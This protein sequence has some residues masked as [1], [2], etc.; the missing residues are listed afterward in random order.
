VA[1]RYDILGPLMGSC[2]HF[3]GHNRHFRA[4]EVE[5]FLEVVSNFIE[6]SKKLTV[7]YYNNKL[8]I[9]NF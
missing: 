3:Q 1:S 8:T 5:G 2:K 4:S 9:Q 6:A 7:K